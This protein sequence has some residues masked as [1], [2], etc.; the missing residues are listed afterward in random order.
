[1]TI[2]KKTGRL[3]KPKTL[4]QKIKAATTRAHNRITGKTK[5]RKPKPKK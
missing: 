1:M 4:T 2:N 5:P 3:V